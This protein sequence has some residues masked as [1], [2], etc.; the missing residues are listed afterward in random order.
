MG[1][2]F[3]VRESDTKGD[4]FAQAIAICVRWLGSR[5]VRAGDVDPPDFRP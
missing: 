3:R 1:V 5:Q 2:G 4:A